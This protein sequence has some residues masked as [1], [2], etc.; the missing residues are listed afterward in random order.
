MPGKIKSYSRI[1]SGESTLIGKGSLIFFIK[2]VVFL[3]ICLSVINCHQSDQ[4]STIKYSFLEPTYDS[5]Q[6]NTSSDTIT[7][8]L[9]E[10]TSNNVKSF[11]IFQ[12]NN[13]AYISFH[14]RRSETINVYDFNRRNLVKQI[15][16]KSVFKN[17]SLYK[18]SVFVK[19]FDSIFVTNKTKLYLFNRSG[20]IKKSIEF[21]SEPSYAWPIFESCNLPVFTNT[22]LY[23]IVRPN[24]NS[25][26]PNALQ[27]WKVIYEFDLNTAKA[28]L[29]YHLPEL[30]QHNLFGYQFLDYNFCFNN[31]GHFVFSFPA[32]T[33]LYE[34]D[35]KDYHL[36]YFA[37]SQNQ[38]GVIEPVNKDILE[39]NEGLKAYLTRD[40]YGP[41]FFDP[42]KKYYLRQAKQKISEEEFISKSRKRKQTIIIFNENFKIIGESEISNELSFESL[43]FTPTGQIYAR[44]NSADEFALHFVQLSYANRHGI[45]GQL[46]QK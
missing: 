16:L 14:D 41:V 20:E 13:V 27:K 2:G 10:N 26:S 44:V 1:L 32:D 24:V 6:L 9:D 11:N 30:Y 15:K 28:K 21:L 17:H 36:S 18:T 12:E 45:S 8:P 3:I 38:R 25:I 34:T 31:H 46:T 39:K 40:S 33:T 35:L 29:Y 22:S 7:F 5:I 42:T 19:T 37:R 43:F 23:A 4:A